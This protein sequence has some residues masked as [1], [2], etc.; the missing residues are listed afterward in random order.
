M[1]DVDAALH[2]LATHVETPE[3]DVAASV[4]AR[5]EHRPRPWRRWALAVVATIAAVL[6][7][8]PGTRTAIA[9]W[10]GLDGVEVRYEDRPTPAT[11]PRTSVLDLG[12]EVRLDIAA[13]RLG[14]RPLVARGRAPDAVHADGSIVTIRYA[15]LLLSQFP[16]GVAE[17]FVMKKLVPYEATIRDVTVNGGRGLWIEGPHTVD[18]ASRGLRQAG[19]TLLWE[20][21]P[22]TLRLEGAASLEEALAFAGT[23]VP[24]AV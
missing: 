21:G 15:P 13:G 20:Q 18:F 23:L 1:I 19:S 5:L 3:L 11:T 7:I 4:R 8:V 22:L 24:A 17:P 6:G 2:D 12:D 10:F 16:G 14:H 9:E